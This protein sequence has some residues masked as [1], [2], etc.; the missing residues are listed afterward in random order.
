M[1]AAN[2]MQSFLESTLDQAEYNDKTLI[3]PELDSVP[4]SIDKWDLQAGTF[5]DSSTQEEKPWAMLNLQ[6]NVD[7]Q[8]A[9]EHCKRDK[10][11]V[12]QTV[13][14]SLTPDNK[15]DKDNNQPLIR[16]CNMFKIDYKG[17]KPKAIFESF[18]GQFAYLK[19]RHRAL[20][21]KQKEPLLDEE[22]NQRYSAEVVGVGP[23]E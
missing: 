4:A 13:S 3:C 1:S 14:L 20:I 17:S 23:E 18:T 16:L 7:S 5:M 21:N 8:E 19:V 12:R 22:G 15:L 6:W 9:R 2:L 10:V 11:I